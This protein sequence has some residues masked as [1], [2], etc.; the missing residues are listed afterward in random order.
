MVAAVEEPHAHALDRVAGHRAVLH[1]LQHAL[2]DRRDE[3]GRDHAALDR[4]DELEAV[5]VGQR[6]DLDVAVAEL[7]APARLLL[8]APVRLGGAADRLL[9]GHARRLEVDL[10]AE[11][12]L[13]PVDDHLDVDLREAR[14]DL[15]AGLRVAVQVDRRVLLLQAAQR[16]VGLVLVARSAPSRTPS[17]APAA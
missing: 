11:A 17:P 4:V 15:L 12:R 3:A 7:A 10:R 1:R 16:R 5:A 6:L 9:V 2:L 14:D 13:H 8:V